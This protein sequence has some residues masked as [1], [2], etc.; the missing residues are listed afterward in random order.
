M[1][2]KIRVLHAPT[3]VGGNPQ[4]LSYHLNQLGLK[5]TSLTLLQNYMNYPADIVL[6][7]QGDNLI[8]RE[9]NRIVFI[10]K[11]A[12]SYDVVHYNSGC[13]LALP[14]CSTRP[15]EGVARR[16][17]R[18][19]YSTYTSLLQQ[20]ELALL[21]LKNIPT[22]IHYQGDDARQGDYCIKNYKYTFA[23]HVDEQYYYPAFDQFKRDSILRMSKHC[24]QI[25]AVNPDLLHVLPKGSRFIPY[26]HISLDDWA[27]VYNQGESDR[28]LRIGH[29]P[30]NRKV[31]GTQFLI[32]ALDE[33]KSEGYRFELVLVEGVSHQQA[34]KLYESIDLLVDQLLCG[35]Y[36]G[37]AVE[38]MAL[39]KPVLV[40]LREDD[41][42]FIPSDMRENLPFVQVNPDTI[43]AGLKKMLE[44][45]RDELV[46][47][48]KSSRSYVEM[49]H[50][51]VKIAQEIKADYEAALKKRGKP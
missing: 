32:D 4:G 18:I 43:E 1:R 51:P 47:L 3:T 36:G 49:W 8:K 38:V 26:S 50:D 33:L 21:R 45:P 40:Y 35:W 30:S 10:A 20:V 24:D 37:L 34:R 29:A 39:G 2:G 25:Y 46:A 28:P 7:K 41:L 22:F 6:W 31:K 17:I 19:I 11:M 5:S 9:F 12:F 27:P 14:S 13:T 48:G 44:M 42:R 23:T 16:F 15:G